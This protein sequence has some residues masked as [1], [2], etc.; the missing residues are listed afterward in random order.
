MVLAFVL[1]KLAR[2]SLKH[3][4]VNTSLVFIYRLAAHTV[5]DVVLQ[6]VGS[7]EQQYVLFVD[8]F[9]LVNF[10]SMRFVCNYCRSL[11]QCIL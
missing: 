3:E 10:D 9:D 6:H 5:S 8:V 1:F 7:I 2:N 11:C 4:I